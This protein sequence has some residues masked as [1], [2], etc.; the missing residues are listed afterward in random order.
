VS[1]ADDAKPGSLIFVQPGKQ[2]ADMARIE[3]VGA[4]L[5]AEASLDVLPPAAG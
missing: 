5:C 4:I 3:A 2:P 1:S